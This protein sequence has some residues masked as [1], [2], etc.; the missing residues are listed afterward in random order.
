MGTFLTVAGVLLQLIGALVALRGLIKTHDAFADKSVRTLTGEAME[1][2]RAWLAAFMRRLLRR[3]QNVVI[4]VGAA[5]M[6]SMMGRARAVVTWGPLTTDT[7]DALREL[8]RRTRD[9]STRI[10]QL[11]VRV[12]ENDDAGKAALKELR[13]D[14][15]NTAQ[16]ANEAVRSAAIEGLV[17]EAVG[18]VLVIIG[19]ILQAGGALITTA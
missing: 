15:E 14:L 10:D 4:G 19:G 12:E 2:R 18:L 9:L 17:G 8:D 3:R 5:E 6:V 16:Q 13:S 11:D 1:R 7:T